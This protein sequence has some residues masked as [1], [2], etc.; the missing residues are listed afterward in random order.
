MGSEMCIRD[1]ANSGDE[2]LIIIP[3]N[4]TDVYIVGG[5]E[6]ATSYRF[7]VLAYTRIG[8]GP[9]TIHL[10]ITTL[11]KKQNMGMH[12]VPVGPHCMGT[13]CIDRSVLLHHCM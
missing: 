7:S 1:R 11:R 4:V 2:M 5:L 6:H 13:L 10:T 8:D 3:N 9:R 12:V